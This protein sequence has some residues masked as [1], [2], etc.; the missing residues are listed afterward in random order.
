MFD[1]SI[2][3]DSSVEDD[4]KYKS[5]TEVIDQHNEFIFRIKHMDSEHP[6]KCIKTHIKNNVYFNTTGNGV[7]LFELR[8]LDNEEYAMFNI[9]VD[10]ANID[11]MSN[12]LKFKVTELVR[13]LA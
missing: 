8:F 9:N 13:C 12:A 5:L 3:I 11:L 10:D 7:Y 6:V 1:S 2:T 4:S